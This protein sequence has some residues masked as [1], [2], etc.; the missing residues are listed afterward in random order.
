MKSLYFNVVRA[1]SFD[2]LSKSVAEEAK[3]SKDGPKTEQLPTKS[4]STSTASA[5][6]KR[7]AMDPP[8]GTRSAKRTR[9][10]K[11]TPFQDILSFVG[12]GTKEDLYMDSNGSLT[13]ESLPSKQV[14]LTAL[15]Y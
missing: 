5:G 14:K 15:H 2:V 7:Q 9:L 3:E 8:P 4:S 1:R 12:M 13:L 11:G 10:N 6:S